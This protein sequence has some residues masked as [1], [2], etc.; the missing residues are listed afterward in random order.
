M[1]AF[2]T[3]LGAILVAGSCLVSWA[4]DGVPGEAAPAALVPAAV[5][6]A[7]GVDESVLAAVI[8]HMERHLQQAPIRLP[9]ISPSGADTLVGE[10][11]A[12]GAMRPDQAVC[13][14][15]LVA[16]TNDLKTF[17]AV[18]PDSKAGVINVSALAEGADGDAAL[19]GKRVSKEAVNAALLLNGMKPCPNPR[20]ALFPSADAG[21]VDRKGF[22]ACPPCLY[23]YLNAAKERGVGVRPLGQ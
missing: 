17:G 19:V 20:C 5:A 4:A 12:L 16:H 15:G 18:V 7:P 23:R 14:I 22:G 2:V 13:L 6:R 3:G 8:E 9:V 1:K 21:S 10:A 11:K